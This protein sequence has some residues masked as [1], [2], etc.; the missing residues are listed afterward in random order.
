MVMPDESSAIV[1]ENSSQTAL[2]TVQ[3][4]LFPFPRGKVRLE[5]MLGTQCILGSCETAAPTHSLLHG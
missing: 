1:S 2:R 3:L 5:P 4:G